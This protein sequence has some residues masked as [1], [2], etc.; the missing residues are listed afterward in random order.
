M[1]NW[2]RR[3]WESPNNWARAKGAAEGSSRY[4]GI[5][6]RQDSTQA[7][8]LPSER[9]EVERAATRCSFGRWEN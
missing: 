7:A 2:S 9:I 4:E 8:R 1:D 5:G 3:T 6:P